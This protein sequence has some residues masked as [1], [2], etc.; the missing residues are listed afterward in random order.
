MTLG[1]RYVP[2]PVAVTVVRRLHRFGAEVLDASGRRR[3]A[4]VPN[5]GRMAE[6]LRPNAVG[7]M[8]P[9]VSAARVTDGTLVSLRHRASWVSIDTQLPNR[10][11]GATLAA[12]GGA[13]SLGLAPGRWRPEVPY[14]T[15]RFDFARFDGGPGSPT[16]LLEVKSANLRV[17]SEAHFPDAPTSRGARHVRELASAARRGIEAS[18]LF[19][20]Q[21]SDIAAVRPNRAMDPAFAD[22]C[23]AAA[24]A[25]VRFRAARLRVRPEGAHWQSRVPVR[26]IR[27]SE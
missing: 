6:L 27:G 1:V 5:P 10:L 15:S 11:V 16:A 2:A 26:G 22:A 23:D 21:R 4:H 17:G 14:G 13:G 19:V 20:A 8:V 18:V 24:A 9:A 25:G 3:Y 7:S 12:P